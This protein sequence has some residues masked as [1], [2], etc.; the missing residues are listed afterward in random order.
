MRNEI[1][2]IKGIIPTTEEL[3]KEVTRGWIGDKKECVTLSKFYK[4][5]ADVCNK[6]GLYAPS[7]AR[8][9]DEIR[10]IPYLELT[11]SATGVAVVMFKTK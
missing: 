3:F 11:F 5:M 9:V 7:Y 10:H 2:R 1:N 4:R 6:Y 8:M